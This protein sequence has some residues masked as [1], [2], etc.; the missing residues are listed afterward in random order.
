MSKTKKAF[1]I[2]ESLLCFIHD[3]FEN[4]CHAEL[5]EAW[6]VGLSARVFDRL[7]LTGP[8]LLFLSSES[9]G[10]KHST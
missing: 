6:W 7:R 8:L 9:N 3:V 1:P 2:R 5:V 4:G 10:F